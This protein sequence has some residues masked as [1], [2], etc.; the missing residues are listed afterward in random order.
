M[1]LLADNLGTA[2]VYKQVGFSLEKQGGTIEYPRYPCTTNGT[3][4]FFYG[5]VH[6]IDWAVAIGPHHPLTIDG[7]KVRTEGAPPPI[8]LI[9][10]NAC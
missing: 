10:F 1:L 2:Y 8:E 6:Y 9:L 4:D 5:L 3:P 7:R